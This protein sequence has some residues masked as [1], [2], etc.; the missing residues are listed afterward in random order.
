M[1]LFTYLAF[2]LPAFFFFFWLKR[3]DKLLYCQTYHVCHVFV[4]L[5]LGKQL[6]AFQRVRY[7]HHAYVS[8][9][10]E[11]TFTKCD[12]KKAQTRVLT[13][14]LLFVLIGTRLRKMTIMNVVLTKIP[15]NYLCFFR[16]KFDLKKSTPC[17]IILSVK[18]YLW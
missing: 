16:N 12:N 7:F 10:D 6:V 5:N 11:R 17:N 9:L 13:C 4:L 15:R 2:G 3:R 8:N 14:F 1:F 18:S